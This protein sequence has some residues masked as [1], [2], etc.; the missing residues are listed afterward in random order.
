MHSTAEESLGTPQLPTPRA[1]GVAACLGGRPPV[2]IGAHQLRVALEWVRRGHGVVP[3]SR[4][5]KRA[6]V[7]GFRKD[8]TAEKL[9]KFMDSVQ[10]E[11]WWRGQY[12][13]AHVGL[14]TGRGTDGRGLVVVDCDMRKPGEEI[15]GRFSDAQSGTDVLEALMRDAGASWP[16]TYEVM[17][18]SGGLHLYFQQPTDGPLIGCATGDHPTPPHIGPMVDVRGIGGYVIAAGSYSTAQGRAYE[19][20]SPAGLGPQPLPAWLLAIMRRPDPAPRPATQPVIALPTGVDATR[21][22][23]SAEAAL[24]RCADKLAALRVGDDRR[25]RTYAYARWLGQISHT[26]PRVLTEQTVRDALLPASLACGVS[27]AQAEKSIKNG[28][29]RGITE[30][31]SSLK[32]L[33]G[34]A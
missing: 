11:R 15:L 29:A 16:E 12:R 32:S 28:W 5:D 9:A 21:M 23:R 8:A 13:R 10:V 19:R 4:A 3:C 24:Q 18:P 22:E 33:G 26:A 27:N 1:S 6:M 14:L 31:Q 30:P 2:D 34:A 7:G 20:V 25:D 17:T